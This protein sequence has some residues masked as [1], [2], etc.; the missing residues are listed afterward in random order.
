MM[1][2][3]DKLCHGDDVAK[4]KR[5]FCKQCVGI[6]AKWPAQGNALLETL[7][8]SVVGVVGRGGSEAVPPEPAQRASYCL[9]APDVQR[10]E[11][12]ACC[13]T[14]WWP[15]SAE[16]TKVLIPLFYQNRC[17]DRNLLVKCIQRSCSLLL[18]ALGF[19]SSGAKGPPWC[20]GSAAALLLPKLSPSAGCWSGHCSLPTLLLLCS[21]RAVCL[22]LAWLTVSSLEMAGWRCSRNWK[23]NLLPG[24]LG[25]GE[26][27]AFL[28]LPVIHCALGTNGKQRGQDSLERGGQNRCWREACS[29]Q[30]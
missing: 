25:G 10:A 30:W 20:A 28:P 29:V 19:M 14:A 3:G 17:P 2:L 21:W 7:L 23:L 16:W 27:S 24:S 18:S 13:V 1:F 26:V 4:P 5:C 8:L 6:N 9:A 22:H 11:R 12:A 15:I